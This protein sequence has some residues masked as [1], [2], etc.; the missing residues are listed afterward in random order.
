MDMA[1]YRQ[2]ILLKY[3]SEDAAMIFPLLALMRHR[4]CF[5]SFQ[6]RLEYISKGWALAIRNSVVGINSF[7]G[8]N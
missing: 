6:S 4:H 1:L 2:S 8:E 7:M 5:R 3:P